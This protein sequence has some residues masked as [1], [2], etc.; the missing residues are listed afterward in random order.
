MSVALKVGGLD[1]KVNLVVQATTSHWRLMFDKKQ[2]HMGGGEIVL[3]IV[4]CAKT[5]DWSG[6]ELFILCTNSFSFFV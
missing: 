2:K 1:G 4:H 3:V 5:C 6:G